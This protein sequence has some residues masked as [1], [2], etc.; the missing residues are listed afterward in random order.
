MWDETKA[1]MSVAT[2][3]VV[4]ADQMAVMLVVRKADNWVVK[5]VAQLAVSSAV[6]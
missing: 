1:G 2:K 5:K 6:R 3:V 4:R